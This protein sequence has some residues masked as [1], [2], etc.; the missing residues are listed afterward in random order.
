MEQEKAKKSSIAE[1][2]TAVAA[3]QATERAI[4]ALRQLARA[5]MQRVLKEAQKRDYPSI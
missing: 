3:K 1:E 2:K 4:A 5:A